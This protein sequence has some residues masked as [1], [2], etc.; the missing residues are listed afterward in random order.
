MFGLGMSCNG[1]LTNASLAY[2][3]YMQ[4]NPFGITNF[5]G[6][7]QI[8]PVD[9]YQQSQ[10]GMAFNQ[11][12]QASGWPAGIFGGYQMTPQIN[13]QAIV[14]NVQSMVAA[15]LNPMTVN[16]VN[17]G[18]QAIASERTKLQ[19]QLQAQDL[20]PEDKT[21][22]EAKLKK[23]EE[24]EKQLK[25][26]GKAGLDPQS[27]YLKANALKVEVINYI[28]GRSDGSSSQG[29]TTDSSTSSSSTSSSSTGS[30]STTDPSSSSSTSTSTTSTSTPQNHAAW[31]DA[32]HDATFKW[33]TDDEVFNACCEDIT[34]DNVI[35]KMIQYSQS[36]SGESFME[37]FMADADK[38]QKLKYGRH[39]QRALRD[40]AQELGY[41]LSNDPD[42]IAITKE[43]NSMFYIDNGVAD[44]FNA[45]IKKLAAKMG[46]QYDY[47]EY[48]MF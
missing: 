13:T 26:I 11:V 42:Y 39:I 16:E 6:D 5:G 1:Q 15:S 32:F 17:Q 38:D 9:N 25:D 24:Y 30:T 4:Y 12:A 37:V 28:A 36:Y 31:A 45:L 18:L 29:S 14:A 21:A 19:A 22:I 7:I 34:K 2:L 41:D 27:A 20:K 48:S 46:Y 10:I 43:L 40:K 35:E 8:F 3:P 44:N 33:G 47:K 23:L